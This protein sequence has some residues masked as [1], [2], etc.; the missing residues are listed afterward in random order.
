MNPFKTACLGTVLMLGGVSLCFGEEGKPGPDYQYLKQLEWLIG[1]WE[2]NWVVPA[3]GNAVVNSSPPGSKV[4]S[5]TSF[6]W[7]ENKNYIGLKFWDEA[8]G[9]PGHAGFEMVSVD[10]KSKKFNH[11]LFSI[12]G[13][14]G[15]GEWIPEGKGWKLKYWGEGGEKTRVEGVALMVPVDANTHTWQLKDTISNGKKLPDTP[16][17]TFRR[18]RMTLGSEKPHPFPTLGSQTGSLHEKVRILEP[19]VGTWRFNAKMDGKKYAGGIHHLWAP[20]KTATISTAWLEPIHDPSQR[21]FFQGLVYW[22]DREGVV[23]EYAVAQNGDTA[24]AKIKPK[25]P[26]LLGFDRTWNLA[27]GKTRREE[28]QMRLSRDKLFGEGPKRVTDENGK[29]SVV[30]DE[31]WEFTREGLDAGVVKET[32]P[33][34]QARDYLDFWKKYFAGDWDIRVLSGEWY[35]STGTWSCRLA[36]GG[37]YVLF[38]GTADGKDFGSGVGGFDPTGHTW[39]ESNFHANGGQLTIHYQVPLSTLRGEPWGKVLTAKTEFIQPDGKVLQGK[40]ELKIID[41]DT[42]LYSGNQE[43]MEGVKLPELKGEFKRKKK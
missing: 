5:R 11:W 26:T 39:K 21:T 17:V 25:E 16:V 37:N 2:G 7:M 4:R 28:F 9:K 18:I 27:N 38:S 1:D 6:F 15:T 10:P 14:H 34:P 42:F 3:E 31:A 35:G 13:G 41:R 8:D 33:Q 24:I 12:L 19:L 36:P 22:D 30:T 32:G 29:V 23:K 20:G 43:T 40:N